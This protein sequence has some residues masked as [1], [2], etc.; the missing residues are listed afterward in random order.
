MRKRVYVV[1][2]LVLVLFAGICARLFW[3]T[4]DDLHPV[5]EQQSSRRQVIAVARGTVYDRYLQPLV[6]AD[7]QIKAA[8]APQQSALTAIRDTLPKEEAETLLSRLQG[9]DPV[10]SALSF[11]LPPA[12]GI[13]QLSVPIRY[14]SSRA[15]HVIGY[16]DDEWHGVTGIEAGYE[17]VLSSFSGEASVTYQVDALGN[18]V[19]S[20]KE[21]LESTLPRCAGG[22]ALTIDAQVQ[23]AAEQAAADGLSRGAVV[24][25]DPD[26]GELLACLSCPS[27]DPNNVEDALTDAASPL[28]DRALTDYNCG[29]VFKI[30]TAAAA[31][32]KGIRADQTYICTG[33]YTVG[34]NTF[35]C[36]N[37]LGD[38][39]Q[40]MEQAMANSCNCYF[41]Q[42]A[43][44]VGAKSLRETASAMGFED[45][46]EPAQ[47]YRSAR[48]LLP[49]K[50]T[51]S[52]DAALAN[53][54]I[55]Q[56]ELMA[57]P[58][59]INALT[60]AVAN[61]GIWH[62]PTLYEGEVNE[63]GTLTCAKEKEGKRVFSEETAKKL[64]KMLASVVTNGTGSEAS[65]AVAAA[66]GKT[67]TAE[68][69][70]EQDG[71]EV[72]QSWFTGFYPAE[73]PQ[74][75]ITVLSENGGTTGQTAAPVFAQICNRLLNAGLVENAQ[76]L[77]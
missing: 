65:P 12:E 7:K 9:G 56:G 2:A 63:E 49:S 57:T 42:L 31:L 36:H 53:L 64:Q 13:T 19:I 41:I 18:V 6:N 71:K 4:Q 5:S 67:G 29:S 44:A 52:A 75:V 46:F 70:W 62:E 39:K 72:V 25:S 34:E 11:W 30:V 69:G 23:D 54:S 17:E 32:E 40:T 45:L 20:G 16:V 59:H 28:L 61:G 58:L 3:L 73:K 77:Y 68:T 1:L 51:L 27:F 47:G 14:S 10:V 21:Q 55:G 22:I 35:H 43:Q 60:A 38:G 8:I 26:T 66:A 76:D 33:S 24:I 37:L 74:Y 48:A 50:Q 15:C